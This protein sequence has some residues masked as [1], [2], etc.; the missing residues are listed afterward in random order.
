MPWDLVIFY[1]LAAACILAAGGVVAASNPV[2]S[3]IFLVLC[4]FNV[5][6]IFVHLMP[7][8]GSLLAWMFLG[9]SIRLYHLVGI[10]LILAGI[11]LTTRG[12]SVQ[13]PRQKAPSADKHR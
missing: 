9:E 8:F 4:F 3:A 7:A 6:G 12:R 5:A 11:A 2:H 10:S 13:E 1:L